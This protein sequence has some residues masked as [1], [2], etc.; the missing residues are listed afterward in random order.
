MIN[1]DMMADSIEIQL[2]KIK[3]GD[4]Q[5]LRILYENKRPGFVGWFQKTYTLSKQQSIDLFQKA[6]SIFYFNVKDGKIV[7]LTSTVE[8]YIFGIGKI[9]MK[10]DF[11]RESRL[12]SL[13]EIPDI[14]LAD[15]SVFRD[16]QKTHEQ[17]L[18]DKILQALEEPCKSLLT[19]YYFNNYSLAHIAE[20]LGYKNQGV[21]KKKKCLCLKSIRSLLNESK[22]GR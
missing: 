21:V 5:F 17:S 12:T 15:Y 4:E 22:V 3:N 1:T 2:S 13:D 16:E 7:T 11:R 18:V 20:V 14:Q 6:F 9:L 10:E 19:M 8:T